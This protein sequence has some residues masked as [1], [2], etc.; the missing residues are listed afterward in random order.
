M[1]ARRKDVAEAAER[2]SSQLGRS[3]RSAG[4]EMDA[5]V[6]YHAPRPEPA[7]KT[8]PPGSILNLQA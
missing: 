5:F 6:V 3:L 8:A 2:G 7:A 1:W 4:L